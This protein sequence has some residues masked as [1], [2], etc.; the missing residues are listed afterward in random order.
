MTCH[1]SH[2]GK[3]IHQASAIHARGKLTD[4]ENLTDIKCNSQKQT[5]I[6]DIVSSIV[7]DTYFRCCVPYHDVLF[8]AAIY[9]PSVVTAELE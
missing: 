1:T 8:K 2:V 3:N 6:G 7:E 9:C 5:T 4:G